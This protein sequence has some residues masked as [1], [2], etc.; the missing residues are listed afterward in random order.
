MNN[1][2]KY[3][4]KR[5]LN[6]ELAQ[7]GEEELTDAEREFLSKKREL[8]DFNIGLSLPSKLVPKIIKGGVILVTTDFTIS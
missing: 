6:G 3:L 1:R 5:S 4:L 2:C 8:T 7:P